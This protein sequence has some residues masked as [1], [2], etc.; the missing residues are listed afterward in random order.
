MYIN[1]YGFDILTS[2][3]IK[4]FDTSECFN[5]QE[6]L[7]IRLTF[8]FKDITTKETVEKAGN[9]APAAFNI[10]VTKL[11][12]SFTRFTLPRLSTSFDGNLYMRLSILPRPPPMALF[13]LVPGKWLI[14]PSLDYHN[15]VK[16]VEECANYCVADIKCLSFDYSTVIKRCFINLKHASD[17][18]L[19]PQA[20]YSHYSRNTLEGKYSRP[21]SDILALI[22]QLIQNKEIKLQLT[23]VEATDYI[24]LNATSI[25]VLND[26]GRTGLSM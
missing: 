13:T 6:H 11:N 12:E 23:S 9:L 15:N 16:T 22:N 20:D 3:D 2:A 21:S 4:A 19:N 7:E 17:A 26:D 8:P 10:F 5:R 1:Y 14:S 18:D 25:I 24:E